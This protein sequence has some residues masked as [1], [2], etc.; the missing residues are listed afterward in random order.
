[1]DITKH[2]DS[3]KTFLKDDKGGNPGKQEC[4]EIGADSKVCVSKLWNGIVLWANDIHLTRLVYDQKGFCKKN[5]LLIN[6]CHFG[7]CEVELEQGEFVYMSPG[8]LNVSDSPA[9]NMFY[10]PGGVYSGIEIFFDLNVLS[11]AMPQALLDYGIDFELLKYYQGKKNLMAN[12]TG[13]AI[14]EATDL[15]EMLLDGQKSIYEIRFATLSLIHHLI[16]GEA[17]EINYKSLITK[18]QRRIVT[19]AEALLTKNLERRYT[20]EEI[21]EHFGV[22]A[23]AFKKYFMAVYGKPVF[24]YVREKRV[25]K[26]KEMLECTSL[27]IGEIACKCGYEHQGKFGVIF[28]DITGETPLEY[29][30]LYRKTEGVH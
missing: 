16:N 6:I 23:S 10:Y 5:A 15:Y 7:R 26:A 30:R 4:F 28:K 12:L 29:R 1:M 17:S 2:K 9:K 11:E 13:L 14:A 3:W 21:S 25:E 24:G 18:G 22:S 27:S 8:I 20:V 19:E